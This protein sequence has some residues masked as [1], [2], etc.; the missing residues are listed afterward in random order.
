MRVTEVKA[1]RLPELD[2]E[3]AEEAAGFDTLAELRED[4]ATRLREADERAIEREFEE[5]VLDA[6]VAE[7]EIDVPEKLVHARAHEL[8]EQMLSALAP[9]GHLEGGLPADRRQG[10][11]DARARGRAGGRG[12]AAPRGGAGRDRRGRAD[13]ADRGAAAPGARAG[14]RAGRRDGDGAAR[15]VALAR[16]PGPAARGRRQ[17]EG[18]R[19]ARRA[20]PSRS[21][22]SRRRRERSCGRPAR[23][24]M[25]RNRASCGPPA[26][27]PAVGLRR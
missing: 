25:G 1:K 3:F 9:A 26:A 18:A 2:D 4:I 19:A 10:R 20:R 24:T 5:A 11:G 12:R 8:L 22:S 13:R 14:R 23:K 7:A 21:A 6:A 16:S 27:E 15:A 17:P